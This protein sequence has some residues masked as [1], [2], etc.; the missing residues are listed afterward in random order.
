[1]TATSVVE[2]LADHLGVLPSF[3]DQ[4]G[5]TQHTSEETRRAIIGAMG[6]AIDSEV[7]AKEVLE[8]LYDED[9]KRLIEPV[10]VLKRRPDH[11]FRVHAPRREGAV[12]WKLD[13][14]SE[15]GR[16]AS[17]DGLYDS[18]GPLE[19]DLPNFGIGYYDAHLSLTTTRGETEANQTL[20]IVPDRCTIPSDLLGDRKAFGVYANLY[21][22]RSRQNWGAGD[23]GDLETLTGWVASIGGSFVGLNPLHALLNR[24]GDISPYGPVSRLWRNPIYIDVERVPEFVE[25]P[26]LAA[27]IRSPEIA[28]T[29]GALRENPRVQY[30]QVWAAKSL[31]LDALHEAFLRLRE[32]QATNPRVTAFN[33]FVAR[34]GTW[35]ANYATWMAI[36]EARHE[37]NWRM[38]PAD[39][40]DRDSAAVKRFAAEREKRV[41]FHMWAQFELDRQIGHV[42]AIARDSG[43]EIGLYQDMAVGSSGTGADSWA[44]RDLFRDGVTIG[45]P[46]DPYSDFGQNW[47]MPPIDPR[48]L[49]RDRYRYFIRLLRSGFSH[50]GALRI[51]HVM[52]LFRLF[53][54]PEGGTGRDGAYVR[55]PSE[56]L[57]GILALESHRHRALVVGE[58]LGVVPEEVPPSMKQWG[59]LSSKVLYFE[60]ENGGKFRPQSA[61]KAL[62]LATANTHDLSTIA[63]FWAG[64]DLELRKSLGLVDEANSSAGASERES[65]KLALLDRLREAGALPLHEQV[66]VTSAGVPAVKRAVNAFLCESPAALVAISLD[67]LGGETEPVNVPGVGPDKYPCWGR[68]MRRT[69]E[70][71]AAT[72]GEELT[73]CASRARP[74]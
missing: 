27:R 41:D 47:G 20:I 23:V 64:R 54:I 65:E 56:D 5:K 9:R 60:R 7:R 74:G 18:A 19:I 62:S 28:A 11:R 51:D 33:E 4:T 67:D 38:W 71:I 70:E 58:D 43:M 34:G 32:Q 12:R 1:M 52:G 17:R 37:W 66:S 40:Q 49:R 42:A 45:A 2:L 26:V 21:S 53:W 31:A 72:T 13:I 57:L 48:A 22:V 35:L 29:L 25:A 44:H 8:Q 6:F 63:G 68:K 50:A 16:I 46:P 39:L 15:R 61:Y 55:Y 30:E 24:G 14:R 59:L 73:G 36:A 69:I 10:Q 3:D